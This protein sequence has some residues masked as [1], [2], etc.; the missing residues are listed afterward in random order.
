MFQPPEEDP[1]PTPSLSP[2]REEYYMQPQQM[3]KRHDE[4]LEGVSKQTLVVGFVCLVIGL[5]LGK[6]LTPIVLRQ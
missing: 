5:L 2:T 1:R 4:F 6:S 3:F